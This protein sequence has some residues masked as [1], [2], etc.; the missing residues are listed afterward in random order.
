MG[1]LGNRGAFE[2]ILKPGWC[3]MQSR[4]VIGGLA[5]TPEDGG[6]RFAGC[7]TLRLPGSRLLARADG[8]RS[9]ERVIAKLR[10]QLG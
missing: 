1:L 5:A 9:A 4:L 10:T 2:V 8:G 7:G 6:T 3:L